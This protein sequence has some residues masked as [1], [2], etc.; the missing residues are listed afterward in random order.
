METIH[1]VISLV[2]TVPSDAPRACRRCVH[3]RLHR[4]RVVPKRVRDLQVV[5]I[6]YRCTACGRWT[7]GQVTARRSPERCTPSFPTERKRDMRNP[8]VEPPGAPGAGCHDA[9]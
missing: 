7:R 3:W 9:G 2:R 6:R 8:V 4:H 5:A 1:L